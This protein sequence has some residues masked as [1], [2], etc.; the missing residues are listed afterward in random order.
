MTVDIFYGTGFDIINIPCNPEMLYTEFGDI[1]HRK[2]FTN[3]NIVQSD[4]LA[5]III[6]DENLDWNRDADYVVISDNKTRT[7]Y[8]VDSYEMLSE[9]V[10][11]FYLVLDPYNT[12]GGMEPVNGHQPMIVLSGS[13]NRL[14]VPLTKGNIDDFRQCEDDTFFTL[15][16]PFSPSGRLHMH[17]DAI[18]L[19]PYDPS[20][21]YPQPDPPTPPTPI[22]GALSKIIYITE[23][24]AG[25]GTKYEDIGNGTHII[26]ECMF[27]NPSGFKFLKW[28][29]PRTSEEYTIGSSVT[30]GDGETLTLQAVWEEIEIAD[31]KNDVAYRYVIRI[32]GTGGANEPMTFSYVK[33]AKDF[34]NNGL[35]LGV[36]SNINT[37]SHTAIDTLNINDTGLQACFDEIEEDMAGFTLTQAQ[38]NAMEADYQTWK[39]QISKFFDWFNGFIILNTN[40]GNIE[41][42]RLNDI[43]NVS[44]NCT[45]GSRD[46]MNARIDIGTQ[47]NTQPLYPWIGY[48]N[49]FTDGTPTASGVLY[50]C[51]WRSSRPTVSVFNNFNVSNG[52]AM[53]NYYKTEYYTDHRVYYSPEFPTTNPATYTI[54]DTAWPDDNRVIDHWNTKPDGTGD[55]Y[56]KG[57]VITLYAGQILDLYPIWQS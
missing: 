27:F 55:N 45:R 9:N 39:G 5:N 34:T 4:W 1:N 12:A 57:Q 42:I 47:I 2:T 36:V 14:S 25:S 10:C 35:Y 30:L 24:D 6:E 3:V 50:S 8:T 46:G 21:P 16:E 44:L 15:D 13:A 11:K 48:P 53:I 43:G 40:V 37:S 49:A 41:S 18:P 19:T 54:A 29:D 32:N 51:W 56:N 33:F 31:Y 22:E 52:N 26:K 23:T 38:R 28:I 7:C 17:Y 20:N